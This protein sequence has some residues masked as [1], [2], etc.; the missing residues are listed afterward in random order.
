MTDDPR[1]ISGSEQLRYSLTCQTDDEAV[2]FCLRGLWRFAERLP[3]ATEGWAEDVDGWR[4][5][6]GRVVLRFSDPRRRSTFLGEATRLLA[7]KWVR[8]AISD[9]DPGLAEL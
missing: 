2:L 3:P 4:A 7:G 8:L 1:L 5:M 6:G 9:D